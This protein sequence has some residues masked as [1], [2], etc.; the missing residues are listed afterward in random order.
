MHIGLILPFCLPMQL[1]FNEYQ[2]WTSTL[3]LHSSLLLSLPLFVN[4]LFSTFNPFIPQYLLNTFK[5]H[6]SEVK[7]SFNLSLSHTQQIFQVFVAG[8]QRETGLNT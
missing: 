8:E 5:R 3:F 2:S 1:C 7:S 4:P 6:V